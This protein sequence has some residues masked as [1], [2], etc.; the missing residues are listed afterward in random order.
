MMYHLLLIVITTQLKNREVCIYYT[1][2]TNSEYGSTFTF[3]HI[4]VVTINILSSLHTYHTHP[5][6]IGLHICM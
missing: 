6:Y 1:F 5:L 2:I 4:Y 3:T